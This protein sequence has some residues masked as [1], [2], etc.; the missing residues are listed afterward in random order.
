[1]AFVPLKTDDYHYRFQD[2]DSMSKD[3]NFLKWMQP[4]IIKKMKVPKK[5]KCKY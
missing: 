4:Y 2:L 3:N 1:M 5:S